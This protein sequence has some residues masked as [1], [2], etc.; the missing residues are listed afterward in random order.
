VTDSGSRPK[1]APVITPETLPFWD[2]AQREELQIQ[3]CRACDRFYFYPRP[4]CPVC[5][6]GDVEW[7]RVSGRAT[8]VSYVINHRPVPGWEDDAPYAIALVELEEGPRMATNIVGVPNTIDD[9]VLDMPL[10]VCFVEQSGV[11]V[12]KFRP[13]I[14]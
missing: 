5:F 12:P 1:P 8:L 6:S 3:R 9:L 7:V 10:E 14:T 4:F 11:K 13:A 2:A